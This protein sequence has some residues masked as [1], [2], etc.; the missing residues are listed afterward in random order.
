MMITGNEEEKGGADSPVDMKHMHH[1]FD[2]TL[3]QTT[4]DVTVVMRMSTNQV[5]ACKILEML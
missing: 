4:G 2:D 3:Q 5:L 1:R